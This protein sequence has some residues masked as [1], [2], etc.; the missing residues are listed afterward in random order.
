M[1]GG[2]GWAGWAGGAP[3][4][5]PADS[6]PRPRPP[7]PPAGGPED[8]HALL[9]TINVLG[10]PSDADLLDMRLP[11]F[12]RRGLKAL[13]AAVAGRARA[14]G[15]PPP[16]RLPIAALL[17]RHFY[18]PPDVAAPL[19]AVFEFAPAARPTAAELLAAPAFAGAGAWR[20]AAA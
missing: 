20:A 12:A 4:R 10:L 19:A 14:A 6:A 1:R 16:T 2:R 7:P 11:D 3:P 8:A 5:I 18:V 17:V 9:A 13:A 15:A